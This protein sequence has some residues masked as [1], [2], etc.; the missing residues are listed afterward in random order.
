MSSSTGSCRLAVDLADHDLRLADRELEALAAHGL[1]EHRELQLA[2]ALDLPRVGAL[3]REHPQRH[4][5]DQLLL[6]PVLDLARGELLAVL[7]GEHRRV[8]ADRHREARLVDDER[9]QGS[10]IVDVGEGLADRDLRNAGDRDDVARAGLFRGNAVERVGEEELDDLHPLDRAVDAAPRDL[11]ALAHLSVAHAA[12]REAAEVRRRVEVRD[13]RLERDALVVLGRGD[14]LEDQLA[15][16]LEVAALDLGVERRPARARVGVDDRELDLVLVGAEIDE[17]LVD[18]VDDLRDA[19]VGPVDLVDDEDHGQVRF[20]RLA[21]DEAGLRERTLARVDEEQHAVDHGERALDLTAEVGVAGS[22]DD[23]ERHVAVL[24][25]GVL[26]ENRDA[27][28][29]LEVVRVHDPLVDV[30]VGA[31]RA[32][33]PQ[34]RVDEGGLAVVDVGDDRHVAQVVARGHEDSKLRGDLQCRGREGVDPVTETHPAPPF[35]SRRDAG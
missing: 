5:A 26:G 16:R 14:A 24:H 13:D 10:G 3:G 20:E 28:L 2:P 32:R 1:D 34:E 21:E 7:T 25:R 11:L 18:L 31:E 30:L 35:R 8:D 22:V 4:V 33:L 15:Q 6:Q 17:E 19:R 27:L 23:V 29:A 9:R 12:Q